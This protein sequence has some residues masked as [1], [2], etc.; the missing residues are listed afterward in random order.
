MLIDSSIWIPWPNINF[1]LN[2]KIFL[3]FMLYVFVF[4]YILLNQ[5]IFIGW[6]WR[7]YPPK[8]CQISE[9]QWGHLNFFHTR[10][11]RKNKLDKYVDEYLL[12]NHR[13]LPCNS[14]VIR[15][16]FW[17]WIMLHFFFLIYYY[18]YYW[19]QFYMQKVK[20]SFFIKRKFFLCFNIA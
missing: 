12:Q 5:V 15:T 4:F 19:L 18:D 10:K 16:E 6:K 1:T 2:L 20:K 14:T 3:A 13:Y 7:S 17:S 8:V 9:L 11:S